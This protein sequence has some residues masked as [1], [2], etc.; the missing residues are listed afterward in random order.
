MVNVKSKKER[1]IKSSEEISKIKKAIKYTEDAI[2]YAL[3]VFIPGMSEKELA[4][5][6]RKWASKHKLRVGFCIVQGDKNTAGIHKKPTNHKI[7]KILLLDVGVVYKGYFGDITRT[8]LI[9]PDKQM[10]KFYS[11]L[12]RSYNRAIKNIKLGAPC[13]KPE[14]AARKL[15]GKHGK[16]F[17]HSL[18]HGVGLQV[19]EHPKVSMKSKYVFKKNMVFT[20]EPGIYIKGKF[21]VRIE[22]MFL[23]KNRVQKLSTLE[24]PDYD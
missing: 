6:I 17:P 14:M 21:G 12:K 2:R 23:M 15:L 20:I 3:Q 1:I 13:W 19:H 11:L 22:D 24:I 5:K 8:Y 4:R 10:K 18:G 9:C 7:R 16:W